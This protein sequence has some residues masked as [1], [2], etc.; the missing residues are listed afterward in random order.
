ME[1]KL[2]AGKVAVVTGANRGIG[3]AIA[4]AF[5]AHGAQV[6]AC[7]RR[8]DE[9][10]LAW[11]AP[12][13]AA[14]PDRVRAVALD[15]ADEASIRAAVISLR[16]LAP[17]IDVLVNNAGVASGGLFQM[18][19]MAELRRVFDVNFFGQ[20]LFTQSLSRL[21][22]RHGAGSIIN[23][24]STAANIADPGT[25]GYGASKAAWARATQT[26]A[27]ELGATGIRVNAIAPGVTQTDMYDQMAPNAREQLIARSAFRRAAQ[28]Q[29][30]ANVAVFLA[31]DLSSFVTGQILRVD[32]GM[33]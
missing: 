1:T 16:Q 20:V 4:E 26:M 15:L 3:R 14:Q 8:P 31:S 29:D 7:V 21:M 18:T 30:I 24:S 12:L 27:T 32:G 10:T 5:V 25:L 6:L 28:P 23:L 9:S 11:A 19:T 17:R 33:I 2:L 13:L 22:A